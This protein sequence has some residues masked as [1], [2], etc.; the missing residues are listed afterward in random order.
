[1]RQN[2]SIFSSRNQFAFA[3]TALSPASS[4]TILDGV[5]AKDQVK[6]L[7]VHDTN[8]LYVFL[9]DIS[10]KV[11]EM[12]NGSNNNEIYWARPKAISSMSL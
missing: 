9:D 10:H 2:F 8:L 3:P 4:Y 6:R 5:T 7:C 12:K 1:M 11:S